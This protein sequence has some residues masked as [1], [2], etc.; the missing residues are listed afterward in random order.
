MKIILNDVITEWQTEC[1][2]VSETIAGRISEMAATGIFRVIS[3]RFAEKE[4]EELEIFL[5]VI[6]LGLL[7]LNLHRL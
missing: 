5:R 6:L 4:K 7:F 1:G 3:I 2:S